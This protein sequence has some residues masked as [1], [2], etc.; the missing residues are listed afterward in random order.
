MAEGDVVE[1]D[2][3]DPNQRLTRSEAMAVVMKNRMRRLNEQELGDQ[4]AGPLAA[5]PD[6]D[7]DLSAGAQLGQQANA[8]LVLS[9]DDLS[10]YM[11]RTK[12]MG[13]ERVVPLSELRASAQKNDAAEAYL[14]DAKEQAR[15]ILED[16]R[17]KA[18]AIPAA[19]AARTEP[20]PGTTTAAP[21][22]EVEGL[23]DSAID[24]LFKG[25][26][27][28][29]KRLLKQAVTQRPSHQTASAA[30]N[31]DQIAAAV[32]QKVV[33]R[34]A[35][36]QFAKDYPTIY[37]DP[38]ARK[39]ADDF[40]SEATEGRPLEGFPEERIG[41][42]LKETGER[43]LSWTR[44]LVGV[45]ANGPTATTRTDRAQR[46]EGID[47]LPAASTRA[48]TAEAVPK[49]TSDVINQMKAARGQFRDSTP[50]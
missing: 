34:S 38:I 8:P 36:R 15:T 20:E 2:P 48:T 5:D 23:V 49:T 43:V 45:P 14:R 16:A 50:T 9:D 28:E 18:A 4:P 37:A 22:A 21:S 47:E 27:G 19:P 40:L 32:E 6:A 35:L 17:S 39:V 46:K 41:T 25:N 31:T 44:G 30:P 10:K 24:E 3:N 26:E 1:K 13:E 42:I 33:V 12:V 11:V 29:A 7:V